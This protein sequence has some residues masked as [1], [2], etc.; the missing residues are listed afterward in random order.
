[1][2]IMLALFIFLSLSAGDV[3][4]PEKEGFVDVNRL[5]PSI[6]YDMRYA[7]Q[8]NFLGTPVNGY[9]A[10][11]C[12]L[13][14]EAAYAL[15]K[16]QKSL[17]TEG[18]RLHV[19]DCYRPQRAVDHFVRWA[20]DLDDTRMKEEYYPG[21][22]KSD[23]FAKGYIAARSGHSRGSTVD[24]TI[25]G[26]DMGTPFDFFDPRSHT[27]SE[28]VTKEQHANRMRLKKVMEENGF[29]N[30]AEEWWHYTLKEEPFTTDY[31]DFA[32]SP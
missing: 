15:Q 8:E 16:V 27:A 10:P 17:Q 24:L 25:E 4:F 13:T 32:V 3:F 6:R 7:T 18:F 11:L 28:A 30:Y 21:V 20:E 2:K 9:E 26:V 29:Q 14:K 12:Y 31:F 19:F 23:L 5:I 1:M 22:D